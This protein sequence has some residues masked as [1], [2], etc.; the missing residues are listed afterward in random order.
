MITI[1]MPLFNAEAFLG[2][3]LD[4]LL[5]QVFGNF[6]LLISDNASTDGTEHICEVYARKDSRISY[7][8]QASN[9]GASANFCSVLKAADT[10]YFM[11]A[12]GD[13]LW[14]PE[15]IE[16]CLAKLQA[17]SALG[18]VASLVVPFIDDVYSRPKHQIV[19]LPSNK[20]W[21][22]RYNYLTQPE[23]FGK[24][25]LIYGVYRTEL[26]KK[27]ALGNGIGSSWGADMNLV[28][29]CLCAA[30]LYVINKPLFFKRQPRSDVIAAA[31]A[32][33]SKAEHEQIAWRELC[34]TWESYLPYYWNYVVIDAKDKRASPV[35]RFYLIGCSL[36]LACQKIWPP[37]QSYIRMKFRHRLERFKSYAARIRHRRLKNHGK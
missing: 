24:A 33:L 34:A 1:G 11:W 14:A 25:N 5:V 27:A 23:E 15:Y 18:L 16:M 29:S 9:Q 6:I 17:D 26:I 10:P 4:S 8:R 35:H 21:K 37:L 12:A 30:N 13:D 3:A 2:E 28:Y 36:S 19:S 32:Q 7:T 20:P 31:H 22:T